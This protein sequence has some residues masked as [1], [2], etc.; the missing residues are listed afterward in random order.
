MVHKCSYVQVLS[1]FFQE[2][3]TVHFVK[4]IARKI[5]LAPTSV[6]N[7][8]TALLKEHLIKKKEA[9]P[10]NGYI[11]NREHE[12]FIF[13]KRVYNLYSVKKLAEHLASRCY[14]KLLVMYGSYALG[15]DIEESDVDLCMITKTKPEVDLRLYEN[16]LKRGVHLMI[17][18]S[19]DAIEKNIK[20]KMMNG[21]VLYG[22]F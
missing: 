8:I 4:E 18:D 20:R 11:A 17:L 9:K 5:K 3:T 6:R 14:P 19:F 2:P 22:G 13:Y 16:V 21:I 15:E 12:D 10:F 7:H 1:V